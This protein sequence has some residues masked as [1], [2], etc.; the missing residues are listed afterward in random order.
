M[1]FF[2][3]RVFLYCFIYSIVVAQYLV[4]FGCCIFTDSALWSIQSVSSNVCLLWLLSVCATFAFFSNVLL[5]PFTKFESQIDQL[6]KD[7]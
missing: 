4:F 3:F 7:S 6:Q 5:L 1:N 2:L